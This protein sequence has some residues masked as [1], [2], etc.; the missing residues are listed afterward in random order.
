[1]S[2]NFHCKMQDQ[3]RHLVPVSFFQFQ[4][5]LRLVSIHPKTFPISKIHRLIF[6]N[7]W[8]EVSW[9]QIF[10][11]KICSFLHKKFYWVVY[12]LPLS[13]FCETFLSMESWC[14]DH[15]DL[16]I[17]KKI[18]IFLKA[19]QLFC[20]DVNNRTQ[21]RV[22]RQMIANMFGVRVVSFQ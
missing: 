11:T 15:L 5:L 16:S 14:I 17:P 8:S 18:A 2:S 1:M 7:I 12:N 3:S 19:H 13:K 10:I 4:L 22:H 6:P 9:R 21:E 20:F